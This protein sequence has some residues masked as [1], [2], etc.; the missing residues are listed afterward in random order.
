MEVMNLLVKKLIGMALHQVIN[1]LSAG[2]HFSEEAGLHGGYIYSKTW[3]I[4]DYWIWEASC[5]LSVYGSAT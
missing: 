2:G 5:T 3:L 4:V 1:E